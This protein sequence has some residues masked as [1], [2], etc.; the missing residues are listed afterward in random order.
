M[1]AFERLRHYD[2]SND[3]DQHKVLAAQ[4]VMESICNISDIFTAQSPEQQAQF[5]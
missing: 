2:P 3:S 4:G 1:R 5:G